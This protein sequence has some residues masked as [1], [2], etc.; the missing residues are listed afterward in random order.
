MSQGR[1]FQQA[2]QDG[3]TWHGG[4]SNW[5]GRGQAITCYFKKSWATFA[6]PN[7][8][9]FSSRR[10][11]RKA[12]SRPGWRLDVALSQGFERNIVIIG[13]HC[14]VLSIARVRTG[15]MRDSVQRIVYAR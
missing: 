9:S 2:Q 6:L 14:P 15:N 13:T 10:T 8:F 5:S 12:S 1:V 3:I 7:R 11:I 4:L